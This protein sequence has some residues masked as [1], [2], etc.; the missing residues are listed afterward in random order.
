MLTGSICYTKDLTE[1][2]VKKA[3]KSKAIKAQKENKDT[4]IFTNLPFSENSQNLSDKEIELY[5][6]LK[7]FNKEKV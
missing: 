3:Q 6:K 7:D 5:Q 2:V 1:F 4:D